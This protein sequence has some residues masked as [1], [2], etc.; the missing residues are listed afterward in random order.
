MVGKVTVVQICPYSPSACSKFLWPR[1]CSYFWAIFFCYQVVIRNVDIL[2][3]CL[4]Y[5][6]YEILH[7]S[8]L[9][10]VR[11][12]SEEVWKK[13]HNFTR[14]SLFST[15]KQWVHYYSKCSVCTASRSDF[16]G[17][18]KRGHFFFFP[19]ILFSLR[20]IRERNEKGTALKADQ[21]FE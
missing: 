8:L 15:H 9:H 2:V 5:F 20:A 14:S 10:F 19:F 1:G 6:M 18:K 21:N 11:K 4:P 13:Q 7:S 3:L 12:S 17:Y 16:A